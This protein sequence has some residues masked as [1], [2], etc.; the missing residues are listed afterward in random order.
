MKQATDWEET[1]TKDT[2]DKRLLSKIY[3]EILKLKPTW[4]KKWAKD[5]NRHLTEEDIQM[6]NKH[7]KRCS[8]S[9][10]IREMQTRKMRYHYTSIKMAKIQKLTTPNSG[11]N[12]ERENSHSWVMGMQNGTVTLKSIWWLLIELHIPLPYNSA[13]MLLN[14]YPKS[15]KLMSIQKPAH[16]CL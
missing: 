15:W 16:K 4:L 1:F 6:V 10:V 13:I 2:S 9:Y 7:M 14:V 8:T 12:V 3:K 5:L 11:E